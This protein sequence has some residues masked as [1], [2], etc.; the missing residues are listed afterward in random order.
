M[1]FF[2]SNPE[3]FTSNKQLIDEGNA[4]EF[5][6]PIK[7]CQYCGAEILTWAFGWMEERIWR[8]EPER[9][10]C[11][12]ARAYWFTV[13]RASEAERKQIEKERKGKEQTE[14]INR[15]LSKSG[16][17][18]RY[19]GGR[20]DTWVA[21]NEYREKALKNAQ[22]Y[23]DNFSE[24]KAKGAGLYLIGDNE[25]GKTHLAAGIA[26]ELVQ[27]AIPVV[28]T[29]MGD[30]LSR[31]RASYNDGY[32]SEQRLMAVMT[33]VDLLVIDDLGKGQPTEWALEKM[34]EL[35]DARVSKKLPMIITTNY[36]DD[37]LLRR[38]AAEDGYKNFKN[39]PK[40]AK[41]IIARLHRACI[42]MKAGWQK[43]EGKIA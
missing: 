25:K 5:T 13:D 10:D 4:D 37:E 2:Q 22:H 26:Y 14:E 36:T 23:V 19:P 7:H 32:E 38:L 6:P 17:S 33:T 40:T 39:D 15:L 12:K 9:C 11:Q 34:F 43:W 20:F 3:I 35:I 8:P 41:A 16:L 30:L 27:K 42:N 18:D 31:F 21:D 29:S 28:M 1:K 24:Y